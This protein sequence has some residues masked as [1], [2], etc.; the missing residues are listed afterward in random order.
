MPNVRKNTKPRRVRRPRRARSKRT[1]SVSTIAKQVVSRMAE[2]KIATTY[3]TAYP[4]SNFV[5]GSYGV[6]TQTMSVIQLTPNALTLPIS[7][8]D[9]QGNRSGNRIATKYLIF[10]GMYYARPYQTGAPAC[11]DPRP[12]LVRMWIGWDKLQ[13]TGVISPQCYNWFQSGAT[14]I[15]P[16]GTNVDTFLQS[17]KDRYSIVYK[18]TFKVG[19]SGYSGGTTAMG[20][21]AS[22]A[23]WHNNDYKYVQHFSINLTKHCIKN[24]VF[25]DSTNDPSCRGLFAVIECVNADGVGMSALNY[26]VGLTYEI[27]YGFTDL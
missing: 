10:R 5:V 9:T 13:A 17:N 14:S 19:L 2:T 20:T 11:T 16:Q 22:Y 21:P 26:P 23:Y 4:I 1:S 6:S 18:K 3:A 27:N 24:M 15:Q 12:S 7:Q 8:G 25:N